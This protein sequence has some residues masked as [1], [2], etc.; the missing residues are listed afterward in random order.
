MEPL[1][2]KWNDSVKNDDFGV[3]QCVLHIPKNS[4]EK[5]SNE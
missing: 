5:K 2:A 1:E 4:E 3:I